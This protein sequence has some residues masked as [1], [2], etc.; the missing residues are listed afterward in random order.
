M[1]DIKRFVVSDGG[2]WDHAVVVGAGMGGLLVGR[3]L[4]EYFAQ[5]TVV[6][7][8]IL[9]ASGAGGQPASGRKGVPQGR[10]LHSLAARGGEIL[11]RYFPGLDAE[12]AAAGCPVLDQAWDALTDLPAGRLPR[13]RSGITM[14][15]ASR[16]LL[17]ERVRNRLEKEPNVSFLSG[18]EAVGLV[19][20]AEESVAGVRIKRCDATRDRGGST[21]PE[22]TLAADLVVD[23]TGQGSRAPRWLEELGY[24]A[25][26]EEVVDARLG[27]ATRW[28]RAPTGSPEGSLEDWMG[29]AVSPGWPEN[30]RGGTL[31]RVEGG[32]WT[33]VLIGLGGDYP[34]TEGEAFLEFAR[35][36]PSP[37]IYDAIKNAEP[38]SPVYGYRRTA[39][40]RRRYD[41]ARLPKNFLA[42]GDAACVLNPSYGSGMTASALSAETLDECLSELRGQRRR[43][44]P[45]K[46]GN[47]LTGLGRRFHERQAAAIEPCWTLTANSD[48]QWSMKSPKDL[49]LS[50]RLLHRISDEV[51]ALAVERESV[52][53]TLLEVKNLLKPPSALLRP[54]ILLPALGRTALYL[55]RKH[56]KPRLLELEANRTV[57]TDFAISRERTAGWL[58]VLLCLLAFLAG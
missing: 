43:R 41:R 17:E 40:R 37:A 19:P 52:A 20:G 7:R 47:S 12:L 18:R 2:G 36:L 23:T 8:D 49:S 10:H 1:R 9:S 3:V 4:A 44:G 30:T 58:I 33:A 34:P 15:A 46:P 57:P 48:R 11:E 16:S 14:R 45:E 51:M 21:E 42:A 13:F 38:V 24:R 25:P 31:R 39:N 55:L 22:E 29:I 28:F 5:V 26:E 27:Y 54:S 32:V 6:E 35:T 50:R 53:L 56:K